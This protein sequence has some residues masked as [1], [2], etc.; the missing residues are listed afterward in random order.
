MAS[1][2]AVRI[3]VLGAGPAGRDCTRVRALADAAAARDGVLLFEDDSTGAQPD[4]GVLLGPDVRG[5]Q[6]VARAGAPIVGVGDIG[7]TNVTTQLPGDAGADVVAAVACGL[8]SHHRQ[9]MGELALA[10]R[11]QLQAARQLDELHEEMVLAAGIQQEFIPRET[12]S[13]HGIE[14]G[15]LLRPSSFVSGDIYR[16]ERIDDRRIALVVA[17][18]VGHGFSAGLLTMFLCSQFALA[19][20][21]GTRCPAAILRAMNNALLQ[22]A[23]RPKLATA[24]CAVIDEISGEVRLASAGHPAPVLVT[25][26]QGMPLT[27]HGVLLGV[28][29]DAEYEVRDLTMAPGETLVMYTDGLE[30]LCG[31]N[32]EGNAC[33]ELGAWVAEIFDPSR[34][35]DAAIAAAEAKLDSGPGSLKYPDDITLAAARYVGSGA[36]AA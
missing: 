12:T 17:D 36:R 29:E 24:A 10:E 32:V 35:M 3:A 34:A 21:T 15:V 25:G 26:R 30:V 13:L 14:L 22:C 4:V 1:N 5:A 7:T 20:H 16:V 27:P 31:Q 6:R 9:I 19:S 11:C 8:A 28:C 18:A 33:G 23:G 2:E